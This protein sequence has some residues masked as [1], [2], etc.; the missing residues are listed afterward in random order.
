MVGRY[1]VMVLFVAIAVGLALLL[2]GLV[3][4]GPPPAAPPSPPQCPPSWCQLQVNLTPADPVLLPQGAERLPVSGD[5]AFSVSAPGDLHG[6]WNA[7]YP[8]AV[9]VFNSSITVNM[10]W[11]CPGC[12]SLNGTLNY[13]LFPGVYDLA[14][15]GGGGAPLTITEALVV[16]FD[17]GLVVLQKPTFTNVSAGGYAAWPITIPEGAKGVWLEAS[18]AQTGC[19]YT[20]SILPPSV[21]QQFQVNRSAIDSGS[22]QLIESGWTSSC[23]NPQVSTPFGPG[24][25]GPLNIS[26]GDVLVF[27]NWWSGGVELTVLDPIEISYLTTA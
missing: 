22:S 20:L 15:L 13:T 24:A 23:P 11:P 7:T 3:V 5:I 9:A 10:G 21:F 19:A 27:Y 4:F 17:R 26:S 2:S 25:I 6:L 18:L 16:D 8:M 1:E 12:Y 14:I